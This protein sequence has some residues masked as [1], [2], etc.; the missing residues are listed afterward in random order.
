[1]VIMTDAPNP[2]TTS[3]TVDTV[4]RALRGAVASVEASIVR[5]EG[6]DA[7]PGMVARV[8][9][10]AG[11]PPVSYS[12]GDI[13]ATHNALT[14]AAGIVDHSGT[15]PDG[16]WVPLA[17]LGPEASRAVA[18]LRAH[19]AAALDS[20]DTDTAAG[21]HVERLQTITVEEYL[22]ETLHL[23]VLLEACLFLW[24]RVKI[25][26][27]DR[28]GQRDA[29]SA[30]RS[31]L[32]EHFDQDAVVLRRGRAALARLA[33]GT[34]IEV[35]RRLSSTRTTRV[36]AGLRADLDDVRWAFRADEAG[37]LDGEDPVVAE[38]LDHI[39]SPLKTVGG[40]LGEAFER[41]RA[42]VTETWNREEHKA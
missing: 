37:W 3:A 26:W 27:V 20:L 2:D 22:G 7:P 19:A 12:A 25:A 16:D 38:A 40:V 23:L 17:S 6:D 42:R 24:H 11:A 9:D 36:L 28:D 41:G 8:L 35:V 1:M 5:L 4:V 39:D 13:V 31:A 15:V 18:A 21:E 33:E 14:R 10:L 30:A 29:L 32:A 34:P